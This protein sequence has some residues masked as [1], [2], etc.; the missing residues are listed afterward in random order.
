MTW[1]NDSVNCS[2]SSSIRHSAMP[3]KMSFVKRMWQQCLQHDWLTRAKSQIGFP[4][5]A[6]STGNLGMVNTWQTPFSCQ[7]HAQ[8]LS[9]HEPSAANKARC[10]ASAAAE[11][12]KNIVSPPLL[13][14]RPKG[15]LTEIRRYTADEQGTDEQSALQQILPAL[16]GFCHD[17]WLVL[18]APPQRPMTEEMEAAGIDPKRVLVVHVNDSNG[19]SVVENALRSGTCGAVLSWLENCDSASLTR[20][21]K[22]AVAGHAWGVMFREKTVAYQGQTKNTAT[23]HQQLDVPADNKPEGMAQIEM[24]ML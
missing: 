24:A 6:L 19:L 17:R 23:M 8:T 12:A 18:V 9:S 20:L 21:R 10:C 16:A 11:D 13:A 4:V 5:V 22:A 14:K 3:P 15:T 7:T 2:V 1:V